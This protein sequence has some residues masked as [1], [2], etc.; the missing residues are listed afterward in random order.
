MAKRNN[1][2]VLVHDL[3]HRLLEELHA[4][5]N[6]QEQRID[7]DEKIDLPW[8]DRSFRTGEE[9]PAWCY[10]DNG[11]NGYQSVQE[12]RIH[13]PYRTMSFRNILRNGKE[14]SRVMKTDSHFYLWTTKDFLLEGMLALRMRGYTFKNMLV[15]LKTSKAGKLTYGMGHWY[16]NGYELMLFGTRGN[17]GRPALATT[18]PNFFLAPKP[19]ALLKPDGQ[20]GYTKHS[21]KPQEAYDLICRNSPAARISLYQRG[22]RPGFYCWGD[23]AIEGLTEDWVG[24]FEPASDP[25]PNLAFGIDWDA[26]D[27]SMLLNLEEIVEIRT[28]MELGGGQV[29]D[30]PESALGIMGRFEAAQEVLE[31]EAIR[32]EGLELRDGLNGVAEGVQEVEEIE[33]E[34]ELE[35][36]LGE[37]D[38]NTP[39]PTKPGSLEEWSEIILSQREHNEDIP[40]ELFPVQGGEG[41]PA[42]VVPEQTEIVQDGPEPNDSN[43]PNQPN[44]ESCDPAY[45]YIEKS[46]KED[47]KWYFDFNQNGVWVKFGPFNTFK[48]SEVQLTRE[49]IRRVGSASD[50]EMDEWFKEL[51]AKYPQLNELQV[52]KLMGKTDKPEGIGKKD[53]DE[54]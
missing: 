39:G 33:A 49:Q 38:P 15:W 44:T 43:P 30:L 37:L 42:V 5:P 11:F 7:Q 53:E 9:D 12:Y 27:V 25:D 52:L 16:R 46:Y 14:V 26:G 3:L 22:S 6:E 20:G 51:K 32:L 23:E 10:K 34:P 36:E 31:A 40:A 2:S 35:P 29:N 48:A 47:N 54:V 50:E 4:N 24:E 41:L 13:C 17:P 18:Q 28:L 1:S 21:R 45:A 8:E 19:P